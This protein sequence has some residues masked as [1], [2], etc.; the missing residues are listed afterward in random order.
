MTAAGLDLRRTL[1]VASSI[2]VATA[3]A[4]PGVAAAARVYGGSVGPGTAFPIF[5]DPLY[6]TT[7]AANGGITGL[8]LTFSVICLPNAFPVTVDTRRVVPRSSLGTNR[9]PEPGVLVIEDAD[10]GRFSAT[11]SQP[12]RG[13]ERVDLRLNGTVTRH[14]ASGTVRARVTAADGTR[15]CDSS[16]LQ[17]RAVRDP[18]RVYAGSA[19]GVGPVVLRR[20]KRNVELTVGYY[21][22][23]AP[24]AWIRAA[25][26]F[27]AGIQ[28]GRFRERASAQVPELDI[29]YRSDVDG[30]VGARRA[31][32]TFRTTIRRFSE[33]KV[34]SRC[35]VPVTRWTSATG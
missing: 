33:G 6:L 30:R 5:P 31:S 12:G 26:R 7:D 11:L 8:G 35:R 32:G 15:S 25:G 3:L 27:L 17:W 28:G 19:R 4:L 16:G 22:E 13:G 29:D 23:C 1:A 10:G 24:S 14:R 2:A 18:G 21:A 34:V 9:L 20:G